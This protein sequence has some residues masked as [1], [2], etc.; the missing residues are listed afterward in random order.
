MNEFLKELQDSARQVMQGAGTPAKEESTWAQLV[1]LGWLLAAVPEELD[2]LGLGVEG[3]VML[4]LE[5]GR[6]LAEVPFLPATM[7]IEALCHSGLAN[8]AELIANFTM[9]GGF[10]SAPLIEPEVSTHN[11][12]LNGKVAT[13][14]SADN[15]S[16]LLVWASDKS[17]VALVAMDAD[18]V[19]FTSRPTWD[20]TRRLFDVT[21]TNVTPEYILAEDSVAEA[22]IVRLQN[23]RDFALAADSLGGSAALL[24][25]T[26]EHLKTRVQF[27][28]PL[29]SFQAL[30]H[31]CAN[32]K[33]EIATAEALLND[34]LSRVATEI[35]SDDAVF[36]GKKAKYLAS[37]TYANVVEDCIQLSGG[38]GMAQ[39]YPTHL[40]LKRSMLSEHLGTLG[41]RYAADIAET[42]L[43]NLAQEG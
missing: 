8:K 10:A 35:G 9:G 28:R 5:L 21:L 17:S 14:Q 23:L 37:Q 26:L 33:T 18:G 39:E 13:V 36:K 34:S 2:G 25:V 7:A 4:H 12:V 43:Q 15:A 3:A 38:I 42:F 19:A 40:Y 1:E 16:H 22:M 32:L 27:G 20:V 24:D 29:A 30:K 31:R 6:N 11:G 41:N